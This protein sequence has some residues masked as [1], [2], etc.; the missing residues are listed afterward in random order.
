MYVYCTEKYTLFV[1]TGF[2]WKKPF[3]KFDRIGVVLCD[4]QLSQLMV[5]TC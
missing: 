4:N 2:S 3:V 5:E 1:F